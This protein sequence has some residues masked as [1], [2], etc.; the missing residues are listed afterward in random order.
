MS[1]LRRTQNHGMPFDNNIQTAVSAAYTHWTTIGDV[2]TRSIA[3][4]RCRCHLKLDYDGRRLLSN[5]LPCARPCPHEPPLACYGFTPSARSTQ[6]RYIHCSGVEDS[7]S[8]R[9]VLLCLVFHFT[10]ATWAINQKCTISACFARY[11]DYFASAGRD[12]ILCVF[13]LMLI[14]NP[15][16]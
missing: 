5:S 15:Y 7:Q 13:I 14:Y 1:S 3:A 10:S 12:S 4:D 2:F 6:T 16:V 9:P 11:F 8:S